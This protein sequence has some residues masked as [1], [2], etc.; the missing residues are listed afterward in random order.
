MIQDIL[1]KVKNKALIVEDTSSD[2]CNLLEPTGS[3]ENGY[4][5]CKSYKDDT[6]EDYEWK[7]TE[8]DEWGML[9]GETETYYEKGREEY[10]VLEKIHTEIYK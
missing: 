5:I 3:E 1:E 9:K 6:A 7:L 4:I 10:D 2:D 8:L